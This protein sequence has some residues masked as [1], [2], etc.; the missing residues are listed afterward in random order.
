MKKLT[1]ESF[2]RA[3]A[4]M[5]HAARPLER[6]RF[7]YAFLQGRAEV[8]LAALAEFRNEDGGFGH[9]LEPD[10][11]MPASSVLCTTEALNV[12]HELRLSRDH[13][14]VIGAVDWLVAAFDP[15][16]GAWRQVTKEA[17]EHPHAPHWRWELHADGTRWP[18][19]VLPRAEI[20]SHLWRNATRVP[21]ALLQDQT[22]RLLADFASCDSL[23]PDSLSRCE[24]F[25]R[26]TEAPSDARADVAARMVEAG[27]KIVARNPQAWTGYCAK[28]LP[29]A[30]DPDCV[31]A[32]AFA[33]EVGENLDWEIERQEENGSW[34]PNWTWGGAYP[35]A[36]SQSEQWWRGT[37]TLNALRSLRAYG[38]IEGL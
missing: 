5:R 33:L 8:V 36:W 4:F 12:L 23:G 16:L 3:A 14:F 30:P 28:P 24:T 31:L 17:A 21:N 15:K 18:V 2:A 7:E 9:A 19:G 32:E 20:L 26:T 22:R 35:E 37:L 29:L 27:S 13:P 38:R 34:A 25:V 1:T 10:L 11:W 6:A